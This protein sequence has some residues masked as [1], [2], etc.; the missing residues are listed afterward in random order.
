MGESKGV[1]ILFF[2]IPKKAAKNIPKTAGDSLI[3]T[4]GVVYTMRERYFVI[5]DC[6]CDTKNMSNH[7]GYSFPDKKKLRYYCRNCEGFFRMDSGSVNV[8]L[9]TMSIKRATVVMLDE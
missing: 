6:K 3:Y 4:D 2:G 7:Y 1:G 8:R 5:W 9:I